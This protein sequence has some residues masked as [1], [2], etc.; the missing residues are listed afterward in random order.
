MASV[1]I[2]HRAEPSSKSN[3]NHEPQ[4]KLLSKQEHLAMTAAAD[5]HT[6]A[7]LVQIWNDR[8]QLISVYASFF[9]SIDSLLFSLAASL[10]KNSNTATLARASLSGALIFH[11][12]TAILAYISSFVLIRFK[13]NDAVH[14]GTTTPAPISRGPSQSAPDT[15]KAPLF[16]FAHPSSPVLPFFSLPGLERALTHP[17]DVLTALLRPAQS[18]TIAIRRVNPF[19]PWRT[20]ADP[21]DSADALMRMLQRAHTISSYFAL[22]GFVLVIMGVIAYVWT[23]LERSVSIFVSASVATTFAVGLLALH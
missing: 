1:Q 9:T 18:R 22:A 5:L 2:E 4:P 11:A 16:T 20:P 8:L 23:A 7:Q 17:P 14:S 21:A 13:L 15:E 6:I 10:Q 12:A 19:A 3:G